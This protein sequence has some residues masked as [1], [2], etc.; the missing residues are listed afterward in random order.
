MNDGADVPGGK[1]KEIGRG[2]GSERL[3]G[4]TTQ[5]DV[6]AGRYRPPSDGMSRYNMP[7]V[8]PPVFML[9]WHTTVLCGIT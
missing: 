2:D 3:T 8:S 7:T 9:P 5:E 4:F 1:D 6:A